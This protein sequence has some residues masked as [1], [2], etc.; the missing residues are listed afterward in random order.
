MYKM[1][2]LPGKLSAKGY[3][4]KFTAYKDDLFARIMYISFLPS[5]FANLTN[6]LKL[7]L[8]YKS[9]ILHIHTVRNCG[10]NTYKS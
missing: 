1:F 7:F 6:I 5:K 8:K 10:L 3:K 4:I 9:K 2:L